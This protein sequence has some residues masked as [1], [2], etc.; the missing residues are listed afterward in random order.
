MVEPGNACSIF[1]RQDLQDFR[2]RIS[3]FGLLISTDALEFQVL[4][5]PNFL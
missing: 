2:F 3:D 4:N 5:K 1:F